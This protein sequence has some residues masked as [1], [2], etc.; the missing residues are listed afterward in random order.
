VLILRYMLGLTTQETAN[1][2]DISP[3]N[4]AVLHYRSLNFLRERLTALGR[5]PL[6]D[7]TNREPMRAWP[8]PARVLR[9]RR[10][11]L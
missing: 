2:L 7:T 10:F 1:Q 11:S 5:A 6:S 3:N 4:V 8:K 9:N